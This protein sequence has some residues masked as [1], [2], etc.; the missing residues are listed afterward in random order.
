MNTPRKC[1]ARFFHLHPSSRT[2]L[3]LD[4]ITVSLSNPPLLEGAIPG[5]AEALVTPKRL[6]GGRPLTAQSIGRLCLNSRQ[7]VRSRLTTLRAKRKGRGPHLGDA[8]IRQA[9]PNRRPLA[10]LAVR[11][12]LVH[13]QAIHKASLLPHAQLSCC[14]H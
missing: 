9:S 1:A 13:D 14:Q 3:P 12:L 4:K 5:S 11:S 10:A 2:V 6:P 8:G 7:R